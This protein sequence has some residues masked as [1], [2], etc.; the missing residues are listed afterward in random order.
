VSLTTPE[1]FSQ[2]DIYTEEGLFFYWKTTRVLWDEIIS[3]NM[4]QKY[5]IIPVNWTS[6]L[7]AGELDFGKKRKELSLDALIEIGNNHGKTVI[8]L[9]SISPNP[10][11]TNGGVPSSLAYNYS[12]SKNGLN[13]FS[14]VGDELVK[15]YSF[16]DTQVYRGFSEFIR[17]TAKAIK[18]SEDSYR[19]VTGEFGS[20]DGGEF[21]SFFDD[22]GNCFKKSFAQYLTS[23]DERDKKV[24]KIGALKSTFSAFVKSLYF[25]E[26]HRQFSSVFLCHQMIGVINTGERSGLTNT[27]SKVSNISLGNQIIDSYANEIIPLT[28]NIEKNGRYEIFST[29]VKQLINSTYL[30]RCFDGFSDTEDSIDFLPLSLFT[31][32]KGNKIDDGIFDWRK[33]GLLSFLKNDYERCFNTKVVNLE[34]LRD[35]ALT[36]KIIFVSA[37]NLNQRDFFV[38]KEIF[39]SGAQIIFDVSG[40]SS[41]DEIFLKQFLAER[42]IKKEVVNIGIIFSIFSTG[43]SAMI[44]F[45]SSDFE[46]IEENKSAK[47]WSK[48][49]KSF[50]MNHFSFKD[51]DGGVISCWRSRST[52]PSEMDFSEIRR[53][54][55]YNI[56]DYKKEIS[57]KMIEGFYLL[58]SID[59]QNVALEKEGEM[60][61]MRFS[62]KSSISLDFGIIYE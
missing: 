47:I 23:L 20:I 29:Q 35:A 52:K 38:L 37:K 54:S 13:S 41:D 46:R 60:I 6:H 27:F 48:V 7:V 21:N 12:M 62:P 56:S 31:F 42:E 3:T 15:F 58:K 51:N 9:F 19:V 34:R 14:I 5:L 30:D 39:V 43:N 25:K 32:V 4:F 53:L 22:Y 11:Q 2:N 8:L 33:V 1:K 45:D 61:K 36:N 49:I 10:I 24:K 28:W 50:S 59:Q 57:F 16:F 18:S 17:K 26:V 44:I 55:L 40:I